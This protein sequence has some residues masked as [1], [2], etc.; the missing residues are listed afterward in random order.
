M[1]NYQSL[2]KEFLSFQRVEDL[3]TGLDFNGIE[4]V[5]SKLSQYRF[6]EELQKFYMACNGSD[7]NGRMLYYSNFLP[8]EEAFATY[9]DL[10]EIIEEDLGLSWPRNL[11]PIGVGDGSYLLTVLSKN[12]DRKTSKPLLLFY[13]GGGD[14]EMTLEVDTFA[15]LLDILLRVTSDSGIVSSEKFEVERRALCSNAYFIGQKTLLSEASVQNLYDL[16][17]NNDLKAIA[18]L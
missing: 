11:F 12:T 13:V 3:K 2:V 17:S 9:N 6:S 8:L 4:R 7:E 18:S 15:Q 5:E 14:L 1:A 10:I 16:E